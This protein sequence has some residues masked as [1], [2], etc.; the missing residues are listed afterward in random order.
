M[1]LA[2]RCIGS[3]FA[4]PPPLDCRRFQSGK[5]CLGMLKREGGLLVQEALL[6][7]RPRHPRVPSK[8]NNAASG[9]F[10]KRRGEN[11]AQTRGYFYVPCS[12]TSVRETILNPR[13]AQRLLFVIKLKTTPKRI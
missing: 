6:R 4:L 7:C 11:R 1:Y 9:L 13:I 5:C 12:S 2:L 10:E 3:A 8:L